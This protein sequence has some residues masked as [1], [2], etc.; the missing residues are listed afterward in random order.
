MSICSAHKLQVGSLD[1]AGQFWFHFRCLG[2]DFLSASLGWPQLGWLTGPAWLSSSRLAW[3]YSHGEGRGASVRKQNTLMTSIC[4]VLF[5]LPFGSHMLTC[6]WPK[7][8]T[9]SNP[10]SEWEAVQSSMVKVMVDTGRDKEMRSSMQL[11]Y[12]NE[13]RQRHVWIIKFYINT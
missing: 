3:R 6:Y 8:V 1:L 13:T 12:C 10:E 9:W 11:I 7:Q 5:K 4:Q 2:I